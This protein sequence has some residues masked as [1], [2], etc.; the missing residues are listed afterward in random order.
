MPSFEGSLQCNSKI[1]GAE[2]DLAEHG[3][4]AI[5]VLEKDQVIYDLV[6]MD[7]HMP[8]MNGFDAIKDLRRRFRRRCACIVALT[9]GGTPDDELK[10]YN[11]GA[12]NFLLKP[13]RREHLNSEIKVKPSGSTEKQRE[14]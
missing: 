1:G 8:V 9:A 11:V 10:A 12:D 14:G 6:M 13:L 5:E 4:Q 7:L 2:V 3:E